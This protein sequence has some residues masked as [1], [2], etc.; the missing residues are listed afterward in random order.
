[1]IPLLQVDIRP[2][3][4][5]ETTCL[6]LLLK[7]TLLLNLTPQLFLGI[8]GLE[9]HFCAGLSFFF[10]FEARLPC[11]GMVAE[12]NATVEAGESSTTVA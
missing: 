10:F 1:M 12:S 4:A 2:C 8:F 5:L 9:V 3:L 6:D 7:S 11:S